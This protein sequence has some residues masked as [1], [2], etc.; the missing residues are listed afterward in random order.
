MLAAPARGDGGLSSTMMF[1]R[2]LMPSE[3]AGA[4]R[5]F[6]LRDVVGIPKLNPKWLGSSAAAAADEWTFIEVLAGL[7]SR[8]S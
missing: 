5:L 4:L 3:A 8:A 1:S 2:K 7:S 6:R